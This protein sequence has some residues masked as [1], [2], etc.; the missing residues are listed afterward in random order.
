[1]KKLSNILIS[2]YQRLILPY[3]KLI[4]IVTVFSV[5]HFIMMQKYTEPAWDGVVY[6]GMGKYL[7]SHGAIGTWEALRP[8]GLPIVV[9][10]FWKIGI[11]PYTAGTMVVFLGSIGLLIATYFFAERLRPR[12]GAIAATLLAATGIFFSGSAAPVT[13]VL[14]PFF[15]VW[16]L[17]LLFKA[18]RNWQYFIAGIV[19]ALS[20]MFRFPNGLVLVVAMIAIVIKI[21]YEPTILKI[22]KAKQKVGERI[23]TAIEHAFAVGGG[24]FLIVI[25]YLVSIYIVYDNAFL[26]FIQGTAVIKLYPSLYQK[27]PWFYPLELLK[28]NPLFAFALL[29][30]VLFW[31]RSQRTL[32]IFIATTAVVVISAYF[33]YEVHKEARYALSFLPYL[34]MLAAVGIAYTLDYFKLS[35]VL[36]FGL[37]LIAGF[38]V[39]AHFL[40]YSSDSPD[41]KTMYEFN[42]Y[43]GTVPQDHVRMIATAPTP[44]AYSNAFLVRNLYSDWNDAYWAYNNLKT[45]A[46]YILLNSCNLE[47]GCA[48]DSRCKDD[49]Q[50]L[51]DALKQ[52]DEQVFSATTQTQC[53]LSIYKLAHND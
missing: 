19:M 45:D 20:F 32:G 3:W 24:F 6:V 18:N 23:V 1:M 12:S 30:I 48:D 25:P 22:G 53:E 43:L 31:K 4:A 40:A 39:N 38:M 15:G 29:P 13:D 17:F 11:D 47:A 41:G 37:L 51:L 27:G 9:G 28:A 16:G 8:I 50:V 5:L 44:I 52:H 35:Q 42:S 10:L 49:K 7:F 2:L 36:F 14:S 34:A 21:L 46:D 33:T 26:P